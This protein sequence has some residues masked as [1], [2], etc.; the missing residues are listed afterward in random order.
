MATSS[1]CLPVSMPAQTMLF[2]LIFSTLPLD[3]NPRFSQP[4]G[5]DEEPIAI[6]LRCSPKGWGGHDPTIGGLARVATR[7]RPFLMERRLS[8]HPMVTRRRFLKSTA[9]A[10]LTLATQ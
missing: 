1:L 9:A 3:A 7:A 5:S 6:L 2:L 10:G 4:S 8:N